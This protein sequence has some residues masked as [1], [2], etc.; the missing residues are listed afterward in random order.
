MQDSLLDG[1]ERKVCSVNLG[2]GVQKMSPNS[3]GPQEP[4]LDA[5]PN[6]RKLFPIS[7]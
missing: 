6:P 7:A 3:A 5:K 2:Q 4:V 1:R